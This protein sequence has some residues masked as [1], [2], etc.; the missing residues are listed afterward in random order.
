MSAM[1]TANGTCLS[2]RFAICMLGV[3]LITACGPIT[4]TT[5]VADATVAIE[6][7]RAVEADRYAVYEFASAVEYLKKAKEEEG[8]SDFHAAMSL[9]FRARRLAEA[10]KVRALQS[11]ERG[12]PP[13]ENGTLGGPLIEDPDEGAPQ[14]DGSRL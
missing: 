1:T 6:G 4:A 8:F 3:G 12:F 13:Q 5:A 9:A 10:A 2:V 7:A 11:P 14:P